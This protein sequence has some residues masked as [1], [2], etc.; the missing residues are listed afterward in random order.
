MKQ[1]V[2]ASVFDRDA[3]KVIIHSDR[4]CV[5]VPSL[6]CPL[7]QAAKSLAFADELGNRDERSIMNPFPCNRCLLN[8]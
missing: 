1:W 5:E 4:D 3:L 6:L 7:A 8:R 2:F